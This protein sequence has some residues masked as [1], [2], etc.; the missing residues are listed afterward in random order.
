MSCTNAWFNQ[1][2]ECNGQKYINIWHA[3]ED[4]FDDLLQGNT[5][6]EYVFDPEF[7][8]SIKNIKRPK[9]LSYS[10][11]KNL[12]V[13]RLK[14]LRKQNRCLRLALGGGTDSFSILKYCVQNDIY[15]D[16]V[17]THMA[18]INENNI[19]N[20]IEYLPALRYADEHVGKSIGVVSRFHPT[21]EE[22]EIVFEHNWY[23]NNDHCRGSQFPGRITNCY[24]SEINSAKTKLPFTDALTIYGLDKPYV[25]CID[26]KLYWSHIDGTIAEIMGTQNTLPLFFDKENPELAVAMTYALVEGCDN[27]IPFVGYDLLSKRDKK[28]VLAN[29]GLESTGHNFIDSALLGK[30]DFD[31]TTKKSMR[32]Q[33]ELIKLGRKDIISAFYLSMQDCIVKYTQLPSTIQTKNNKSVALIRKFCQKVPIYQD[34]FGC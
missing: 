23:K 30:K 13:N 17:F 32:L 2:Y 19:K 20:N 21:I 9:N 22:C 18:S 33:N 11:C 15:L 14:Q 16:E 10:Y 31:N 25:Q 5:H 29:M 26:K 6:I 27:T 7:I 3:Y 4:H 1:W 24:G 28:Q 34:T 12:I 8:D